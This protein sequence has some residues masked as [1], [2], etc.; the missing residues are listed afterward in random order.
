MA[1]NAEYVL[2]LLQDNGL[3]D[4]TQ[5]DE[6]WEK[7]AVTGGTMD[8]MDAL[9]ELKYI[10]EEEMMAVLAQQYGLDTLDLDGYIIPSEVIESVPPEVAKQYKIFPVMKHDDMLT[11]AMSDPTDMETLDSLRYVL[12][13]D[14]D[15]VISSKAQI[16]KLLDHHFGSLEDNVDSFL[17]EISG[18]DIESQLMAA[19]EEGGQSV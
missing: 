4:Q 7:V 15:A 19:S 3:I 13:T 6:G 5:I 10:D 9:K 1:Q 18:E 16:Q 17:D 2:E 12:K 8:I 14:V 11:V